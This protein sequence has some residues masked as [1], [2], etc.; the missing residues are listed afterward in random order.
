[1]KLGIRGSP[2]TVRRYLPRATGRG[3]RG[4]AGHRWAAFVRNQGQA[5]WA[6]DVC[7]AVTVS[8][9]R[10]SV[11][12]VMETGS[13]RLVHVNVTAHPTAAW[14][15]QQFGEVLAAP[16]ASRCVFHDR[17]ST[18][19]T[20]L[21]AVVTALGVRVLRTPIRAPQAN[22]FCTSTV[23]RGL[24]RDRA[25]ISA[26]DRERAVQHA[27]RCLPAPPEISP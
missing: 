23:S 14:I 15:L 1:M 12:V 18:S 3:G 5:V 6:C 17:D 24:Q 13:R 16:H 4:A 2:R 26:D 27:P 8:F 11:F 20:G 7:L 22:A 21:D 9:R 19:S 10:L 25:E